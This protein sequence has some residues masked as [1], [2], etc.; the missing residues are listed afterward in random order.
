MPAPN[1]ASSPVNAADPLPN[2]TPGRLGAAWRLIRPHQWAKN[3]FVLIGL[4]FGQAWGDP[5]R[6]KAGAVA[7]LAFC[8]IASAVY[9]MN[10]WFDRERDRLHPLKR[11][12]PI[13]RGEIGALGAW[14]LVLV[15]V[16]LAAALCRI[17]PI[18]DVPGADHG[19]RLALVL[20]LYV[21]VNLAYSLGLKQVPILDCSMISLGFMLRL[22]AGTWAIGIA[23]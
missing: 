16:V 2:T 21:A 8:A 23:P 7:F 18:R 1:R 15:L 3:G 20:G 4:L 22:L 10:D 6:V 9:V 17:G 12:R 5:M 14:G 13:A 11:H 19:L